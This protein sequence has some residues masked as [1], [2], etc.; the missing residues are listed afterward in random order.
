MDKDLQ[1]VLG[2]LED[3]CIYINRRKRDY[4]VI[5]AQKSRE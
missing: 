5:I 2:A 4:R 3:G 1:C